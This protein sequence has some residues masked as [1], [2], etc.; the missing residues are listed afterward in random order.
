MA[1]GHDGDALGDAAPALA[2]RALARPTVRG[3]RHAL[4]LGPGAREHAQHVAVEF[5]HPVIVGNACAARGRAR[6]RRPRRRPAAHGARRRRAAG[7]RRRRAAPVAKVL[8]RAEAWGLTTIHLGVGPRRWTGRRST[9]CGS[10]TTSGP[11]RRSPR[12]RL[13]RAV[14]ADARVLRAP[15]PGDAVDD[16]ARRSARSA[17]TKG[18]SP[19]SCSSSDDDAQVRT[20]HGIE[21]V[22][23]LMVGPVQPGDLVLVHAGT[24]ISVVDR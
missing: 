12:A 5:V 15:R 1:Q 9:C 16:E 17:R 7:D 4:V 3:R 23:T 11:R 24:A 18:A 2:R 8:H 21:T 13:P 6:G 19:R 14:G 20:A 10:A 22:S